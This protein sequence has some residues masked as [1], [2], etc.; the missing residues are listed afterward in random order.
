MDGVFN[1]TNALSESQIREFYQQNIYPKSKIPFSFK[2]L[3]DVVASDIDT[4][5]EVCFIHTDT[6]KDEV[7]NGYNNHWLVLIYDCLFDSYGYQKHYNLGDLQNKIYFVKLH[8][9]R[10]QEFGSVVCGE[11]SLNF[12]DFYFNGQKREASD[13]GSEY[14]MLKGYTTDT[15]ENDQKVLSWYKAGLSDSA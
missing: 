12:S 3:K 6:I 2:F 11:Y 1:S 8:P 13:I 14:C 4:L 10:I 15:K 7:N 5:P 9:S